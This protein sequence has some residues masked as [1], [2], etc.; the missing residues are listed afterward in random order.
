MGEISGWWKEE[1]EEKEEWEWDKGE[2][3]YVQDDLSCR[4]SQ[5]GGEDGEGKGDMHGGWR[6][7]WVELN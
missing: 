2:V 5:A 7:D 3:G 1:E 6:S 4:E